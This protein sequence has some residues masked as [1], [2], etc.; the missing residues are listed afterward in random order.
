MKYLTSQAPASATATTAS[1]K[2][3]DA[4][5]AFQTRCVV[6]ANT[7]A[8]S[9][10]YLAFG[11]HAAVVQKGIRISAGESIFID[12]DNGMYN[13][14]EQINFIGASGGEVVAIQVAN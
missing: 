8:S 5:T 13:S 1:V 2:L 7:H 11:E 10:V 3:I 14:R 9:A 6:L 12:E 4:A